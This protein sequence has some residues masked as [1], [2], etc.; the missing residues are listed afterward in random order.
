MK[1][2]NHTPRGS[3]AGMYTHTVVHVSV[4]ASN[5]FSLETMKLTDPG[6]E[7]ACDLFSNDFSTGSLLEVF[8]IVRVARFVGYYVR[9]F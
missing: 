4:E 6:V 8:S 3:R 7:R 2:A 9:L 5:E 1:F